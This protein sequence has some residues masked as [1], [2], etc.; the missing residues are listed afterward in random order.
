MAIVDGANRVGAGLCRDDSRTRQYRRP[1][2]EDGEDLHHAVFRQ[3]TKLEQDGF[4]SSV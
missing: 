2:T 4:R 3:S 1:G